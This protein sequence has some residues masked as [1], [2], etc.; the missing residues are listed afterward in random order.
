MT[1]PAVTVDPLATVTEAA[2]RMHRAGVKRLPVVDVVG[3]LVGIVS[4]V[5]LLR[6]F[7]RP[8]EELH[9]EIVEDVIFGDLFMAPDRFDVNV[10]DGVV[11]LQGRCERRSLIR[12]VLRAVAAVDGVVRVVNRLGYD[13]DDLSSPPPGTRARPMV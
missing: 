12:T 2:R 4:R 5:D 8:D 11:T 13:I 9:R 7:L 10:Q 3:R 1:R 6:S